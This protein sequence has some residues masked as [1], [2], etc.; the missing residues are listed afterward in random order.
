M[1][2]NNDKPLAFTCYLFATGALLM[3]LAI[4]IGAFGAHALKN[5]ASE[6]QLSIIATGVKYQ[7]AHGVA[8]LI[9]AF[10]HHHFPVKMIK[11]TAVLLAIGI[12]LFSGSLYLLALTEVRLLGV[13]TPIGGS[14][15]IL[16]WLAFAWSALRGFNQKEQQNESR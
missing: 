8:V 6:Y 14:M 7:L 16:A 13:I 9:I 1:D 4:I 5:I 11:V 15:L 3:A 10:V 12:I 2:K